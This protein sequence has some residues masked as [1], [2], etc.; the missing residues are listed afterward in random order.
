LKE[1]E[2]ACTID[3]VALDAAKIGKPT[4]VIVEHDGQ[5]VPPAVTPE[6]RK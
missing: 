5:R 2:F 6:A 1:P 4:A 3:E